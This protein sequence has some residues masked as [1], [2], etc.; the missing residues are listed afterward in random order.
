[1]NIKFLIFPVLFLLDIYTKVSLNK[2]DAIDQ[3][4]YHYRYI[5]TWFAIPICLAFYFAY[6]YPVYRF[7]LLFASTGMTLNFID[8]TDGVITNPF[9]FLGF[10][11]AIAFNIAD[12]CIV[13]GAI[14]FAVAFF[15]NK[16]Q[17][18]V[19]A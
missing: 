15:R 6:K 3:I 18:L 7:S 8:S 2:S 5:P 13:S 14:L 10:G 17:V 1:M 9:V 19:P 12:L 4:Q 16:K 11:N